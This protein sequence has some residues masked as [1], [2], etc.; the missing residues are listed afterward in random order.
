MKNEDMDIDKLFREGTQQDYPYDEALWNQVSG[1]LPVS[2]GGRKAGLIIDSVIIALLACMLTIFWP[3]SDRI[4]SANRGTD[5]KKQFHYFAHKHQNISTQTKLTD[6]DFSVK[7][8]S[9]VQKNIESSGKIIVATEKF[10]LESI[11][12]NIDPTSEKTVLPRIE[13]ESVEAYHHVI[14]N[15]WNLETQKPEY[16]GQ[17]LSGS[18]LNLTPQ[19]TL[20]N[21]GIEHRRWIYSIQLEAA[22]SISGS[23]NFRD[24]RP[25][26][27]NYR[28]KNESFVN[29]QNAGVLFGIHRRFAFIQTGFFQQQITE[30]LDYTWFDPKTSYNVTQSRFK[31]LNNSFLKDGQIVTLLGHEYDTAVVQDSAMQKFTADQKFKSLII[32]IRVGREWDFGKL[33]F[34]IWAQ[35]S[36]RFNSTFRGVYILDNLKGVQQEGANQNVVRS[37]SYQL[38]FGGNVQYH[39]NPNYAFGIN[40]SGN[41][42][43]SSSLMAAN[44]YFR[45]TSAGFYIRREF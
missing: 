11:Q 18:A 33:S 25:L 7:I 38:G 43:L 39:I 10:Q 31:I 20:L 22:T 23:K 16:I 30:H 17:I 3:S 5:W 15:Y 6:H 21:F 8:E 1:R 36:V 29:A 34:A 28:S 32:P 35:P 40:L 44:Q 45:W 37:T 27:Q 2:G 26:V 12:Q 19:N 9:S 24:L 41:R 42:E 4:A 13:T 14:G